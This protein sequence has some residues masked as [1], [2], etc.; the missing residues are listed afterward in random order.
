MKKL[1]FL[2]GLLSFSAIGFAQPNVPTNKKINDT[3]VKESASTN[4]RIQQIEKEI[5]TLRAEQATLKRQLSDTQPV[6]TNSS[7]K[8]K[9]FVNRAG[10]KQLVWAEKEQLYY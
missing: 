9:L 5:A 3:L 7:K 4:E 1:S 6:T 10:S 8:K 2:I